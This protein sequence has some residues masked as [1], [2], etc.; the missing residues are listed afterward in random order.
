MRMLA[1]LLLNGAAAIGSP[2]LGIIIPA[3]IFIISFVATWLLY[4]HF[5][6]Q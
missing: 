2:S 1:M 4:R 3:L 6:K 5:S